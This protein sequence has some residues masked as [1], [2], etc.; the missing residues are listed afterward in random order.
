MTLFRSAFENSPIAGI[1]FDAQGIVVEANAEFR[2]LSGYE[3]NGLA[4]SD[5]AEIVHPQDL[6]AHSK[7]WERLLNGETEKCRIE[8]RIV[9]KNGQTKLF[10]ET[11]ALVKEEKNGGRHFV[12]VLEE[13]PRSDSLADRELNSEDHYEL[14]FN[15]LSDAIFI[16]DALGRILEVNSVAC[17]R[18]GYKR[19]ELLK[20]PLGEIFREDASSPGFETA[21]LLVRGNV[22]YE[23]RQIAKNGSSMAVEASSREIWFD[24]K[25]AAMTVARDITVRKELE[26]Q[27]LQSQKMEAVGRLAGGVA[28][29]FNNL[30]TAVIS[31]TG[32]LLSEVDKDSPMRADLLEIEKAGKRAADLTRQLLAFS[33]KQVMNI[34]IIDL[35]DLIRDNEKMIQKLMSER[36]A[37]VFHLASDLWRIRAD[38]GQMELVLFNLAVNAKD[39]MPQGGKLEIKTENIVVAQNEIPKDSPAKPGEYVKWIVS[40]TGQGMDQDTISRIFEPFFTTKVAGKGTGLGLATIYGIIAQTKGSVFVQ[41]EPGRGTVFTV[42][43][44]RSSGAEEFQRKRVKSTTKLTGHE[45]VLVVEDEKS[46]RNLACKIFTKSGYKPIVAANGQEAVE[47]CE[48]NPAEIHLMLTDIVMPGLTGQQL[49]DKVSAI[50]PN[51]KILFMSGHP[52]YEILN[53]NLVDWEKNFLPKPFSAEILLKKIRQILDE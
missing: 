52:S 27:L 40:D 31:F 2:R 3:T 18:T 38:S 30:M 6:P 35:N 47:I 36:V 29:D 43:F 28:H 11:T 9:S 19:T 15:S 50:R 4:G 39:A 32:F 21:N 7:N 5:L 37:T 16:H 45:T 13:I 17:E 23:T 46:I 53:Y 20:I 25:T 42:Y 51:M 10:R 49:I 34:S 44:P 41:S 33:R 1:I 14:L 8:K 24:G 22:F 48:N 26:M 12:S